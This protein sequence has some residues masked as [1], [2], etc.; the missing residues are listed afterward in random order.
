MQPTLTEPF[1]DVEFFVFWGKHVLIV[2][3][4]VY[5][6]LSLR[7]GP[8]WASYRTAVGVDVRLAGRGDVPERPARAPTT[9]T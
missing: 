1:P 5:L 6:C 9:A 7:H 3:G 4:A 2:W 8:D